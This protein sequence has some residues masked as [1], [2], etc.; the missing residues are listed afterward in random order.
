MT[1][2][3]KESTT[4]APGCEPEAGSDRDYSPRWE[5]WQLTPLLETGSSQK[6]HYPCA[7]K[8]GGKGWTALGSPG[9]LEPPPPLK[10]FPGVLRPLVGGLEPQ[11][12]PSLG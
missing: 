12:S 10:C 11:Q 5:Q 1:M 8:P 3:L 4:P 7:G 9:R 2:F 6:P